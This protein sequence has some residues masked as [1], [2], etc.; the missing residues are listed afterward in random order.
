VV[1]VDDVELP[2][3]IPAFLETCARLIV[4]AISRGD[5]RRACVLADLARPVAERGC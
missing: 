5:F 4:E 3:A 1:R 2:S